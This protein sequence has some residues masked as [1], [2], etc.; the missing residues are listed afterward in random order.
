VASAAS[1]GAWRNC[2]ADGMRKPP[3]LPCID[4]WDPS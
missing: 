1:S 2:L 4:Q 3:G